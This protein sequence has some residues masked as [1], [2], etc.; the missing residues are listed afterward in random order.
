MKRRLSKPDLGFDFECMA[1]Q[2]GADVLVE[3]ARKKKNIDEF[4]AAT[5]SLCHLFGI[6]TKEVCHGV[7]ENVGKQVFYVLK[8]GNGTI[9]SKDICGLAKEGVCAKYSKVRNKILVRS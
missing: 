2:W 7:V 3:Y 6:Y 5:A 1:C 4:L 8:E 9:T